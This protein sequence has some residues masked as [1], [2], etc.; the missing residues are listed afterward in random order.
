VELFRFHKVGLIRFEFCTEHNDWK[1]DNHDGYDYDDAVYTRVRW[2]CFSQR[3]A[4]L[5]AII[6]FSRYEQLASGMMK[7]RNIALRFLYA[8]GVTLLHPPCLARQQ[9]D[10][11]MRQPLDFPYS[12]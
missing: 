6:T 7:V 3:H 5:T 1:Y 11:I 2:R 8:M 9:V 4:L 10:L 12:S